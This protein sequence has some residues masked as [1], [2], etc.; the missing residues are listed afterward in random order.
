MSALSRSGWPIARWRVGRAKGIRPKWRML[1]Q[2]SFPLY[3]PYL[4]SFLFSLSF[5]PY[6]FKFKS[7]TK[8]KNSNLIHT[9]NQLWCNRNIFILI[10]FFVW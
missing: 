8:F 10:N 5:L 7:K 9:L 6:N 3:F 2:A 1:A 4:F